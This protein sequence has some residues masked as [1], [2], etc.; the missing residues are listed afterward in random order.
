MAEIYK[1]FSTTLYEALYLVDEDQDGLRLDQYCAHFLQSFSREAIKRKI[2]A[3]EVKI[4]DR[5]FPHKPS[6]KVY[7]QEKVLFN[8]P[9]GDLEDEYWR[10]EL[11]ELEFDPEILFEDEDIIAIS[12]PSYMTTHPSGKHL[13]NCATV[14]FQEKYG[15]TIHSIHRIDR[16]TSG[17]LLLDKNPKAAGKCTALFENDLVNKCYFFISEKKN[18]NKFPFIAKERMGS[19]DDFIPKLFVH[20]FDESSKQGKHAQTT[21]HGLFENQNY[22]L[23][24]AFPKTGRQHQIRAHASHHGFPLVGDKLYNGDP[25]VFMRFKDGIATA[26]DHDLMDLSHH[27]LHAV[28]LQFP[29]P[30]KELKLITSVIPKDFKDW[31]K[32]KMPEVSIEKLNSDLVKKVEE[33]FKNLHSD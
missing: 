24:L 21:F 10:G 13:F 16:E 33:V 26:K 8:T 9:R 19:L 5:P 17:V 23:G 28:A 1:K 30:N 4:L 11:L 31:M 15:H 7:H 25:R 6:V 32:E 29:Y 22:I 18:E 14:Y 3:G 27:A 2:A 20:C 12:K